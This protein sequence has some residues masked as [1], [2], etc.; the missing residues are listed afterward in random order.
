MGG[1]RRP[2]TRPQV[3]VPRRVRPTSCSGVG[4]AAAHRPCVGVRGQSARKW[5]R[6]RPEAGRDDEVATEAA[7]V[8]ALPCCLDPLDEA[9]A[10][11]RT[12]RKPHRTTSS[13]VPRSR[14]SR[15]FSAST[16]R[17]AASPLGRR[18]LSST[19]VLPGPVGLGDRALARATARRPAPRSRPRASYTE[20]LALRHRHAE[21]PQPGEGPRLQPRLAP[22]V[23]QRDAVVG[24][25]D[26]GPV[27]LLAPQHAELAHRGQPVAHR[28]V[29]DGDRVRQRSS[30]RQ[31]ITVRPGV[32]TRRP[33][34]A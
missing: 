14:S 16:S 6:R 21:L 17:A 27:S 2:A 5:R 4:V 9:G 7:E 15:T 34:A 26:A 12:S 19:E 32:V 30:R 10:S 22:R 18:G 28:G 3:G 31:S 20:H 8:T 24:G 25:P 33:D 13:P 1:R 11:R 29:G 23:D